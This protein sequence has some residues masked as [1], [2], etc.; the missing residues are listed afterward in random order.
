VELKQKTD[1]IAALAEETGSAQCYIVQANEVLLDLQFQPEPVD[2]YAVQKGVLTLLIGIAEELYLLETLDNVNHHLAPEWT[3]LSPWDEAKLSIETLLSMTTGMDDDLAP[4]GEV[5]RS[6][7]YNNTAYQYLKEILTQQSDL[8]LQA[9]SEAWLFQPLGM[10]HSQWVDRDQLMPNGN[11]FT[12]L[13]STA[14]D[15][16]RVGQLV[17]NRGQYA[18]QIIVPEHFVQRMAE[19]GSEENPAWGWGWWNNKSDR[20]IKPMRETGTVEG[21]IIPDAPSDLIA[22]RGAFGNYLYVVP[23]AELVIARTCLRQRDKPRQEFEQQL[24]SLLANES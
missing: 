3:Q 13:L 10:N 1:Q 22:A 6:W 24:W 17:L 23:S 14:S 15:L 16:A 8:S 11:A 7:R 12:G 2:V 18:A 20:Y 21:A 19:P 4:L 9:L 5:N